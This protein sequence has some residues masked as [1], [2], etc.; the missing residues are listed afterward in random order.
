MN[1]VDNTGLSKYWLL[2]AS[3][4]QTSPETEAEKKAA[5]YEKVLSRW[6]EIL[7]GSLVGFFLLVGCCIWRC[8][9]CRRNRRMKQANKNNVLPMSTVGGLKEDRYHT[10]GSE[11]TVNL[12]ATGQ[13]R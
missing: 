10:L 5:Y 7:V 8:C 4:G 3:E 12:Q 1:G 6:P 2:P 11:S 13:Y 9:K